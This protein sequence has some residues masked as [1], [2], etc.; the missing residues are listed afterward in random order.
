MLS[1]DTCLA[2]PVCCLQQQG[3]AGPHCVHWR[4]SSPP[5]FQGEDPLGAIHLRGCVVTS[6]ESNPD[7]KKAFLWEGNVSTVLSLCVY[8]ANQSVTRHKPASIYCL[9][10]LE[11]VSGIFFPE[12]LAC[13]LGLGQWGGFVDALSVSLLMLMLEKFITFNLASTKSLMTVPDAAD[14]LKGDHALVQLR[15]CSAI[16]RVNGVPILWGKVL[17]TE[18]KLPQY[19]WL[20]LCNSI[21]Y[22]APCE[23]ATRCISVPA[24]KIRGCTR[25]LLFPCTHMPRTDS[26]INLFAVTALSGAEDGWGH[27]RGGFHNSS[28]VFCLFSLSLVRLFFFIFSNT[29]L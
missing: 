23:H 29:K 8:W 28:P 3:E 14:F 25:R 26:W 13:L 15:K 20:G 7:G 9:R 16:N 27:W 21:C 10:T 17:R 24:L 22:T 1:P 2:K 18:G 11:G 19:S 12:E 6:V 5:L 4:L